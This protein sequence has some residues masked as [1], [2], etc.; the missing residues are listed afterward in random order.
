MATRCFSPPESR[1]A[2]GRAEWPMPSSSTT[3]VEVGRSA[4]P[5]ARTSGRRAGSAARSGA[6]TAGLPGTRSRSR[7]RWRGTKMPRAVSTS[8]RAVDGDA[9]LVGPDQAGD[10]VDQRVL[11]AP[12][13]PNSAVSRPA[14]SKR[15]VEREARRA[16]GGRRRRASFD[17]HA[18]GSRR[19]RTSEA[20][21][22]A[23]AMAIETSVSRSAPAS[24]PGTC[25][26]V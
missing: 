14:V 3:R 19:A 25:V 2:G 13:R 18:A 7:R 21:S 24:P 17:V 15:G 6:G 8:T 12:E 11:P 10:D 23:I 16:D 4:R 5:A 1:P 9:A 26:K 20:S 22:A